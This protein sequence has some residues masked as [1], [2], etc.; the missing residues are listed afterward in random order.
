MLLGKVDTAAKVTEEITLKF[1]FRI[2]SKSL[3]KVSVLVVLD[4]SK[5]ANPLYSLR[6]KDLLKSKDP[7]V[8]VAVAKLPILN[9]KEFDLW[10]MRI[11]QYFLMT[12]YSLWEV[13]LN[14]D[15][16]S[17]TRIVDGVVQNIAPT[18]A[19]QRLAK[20]NKLKARRI[21]LMA[22]PD[23][24]QLKFNIYKDAKTLIEAIEKRLQKLLSQL[25]ILGDSISQEDINLKFL[26]SLSSEWKTHTLIWRNK[27]DLEE[28]SLDDLFN[29]LKIYEAEVEGSST[30]SQNTQ[31][32]A[33]VSS[34][35]TDS[36][37]ESVNVVL[38]VCAAS[39][40]A[41]VSTLLNVDSLSDAVIYSF[42]ASQSNSPQLDNEDLKQIDADDL[43]EMDL[44]WQMA[45]LTMR[46]RRFLQRAR[47]NLGANGTT[48]IGFDMSKVK[49]Y[50]CHRICH[51]A[52]ECRS[53]RDNKNKEAPIRTVLVEADEEPTN[54]AL[55]AYAS[56]GSSSS[57]G[58]ANEIFDSEDETDIESVPEQ[59]EPS[60]VLT[61]EHLKTPRKSVKEVEHPKQDEN[62]GTDNQQSRGHKNSWN[63]K[64]CFVCK[65]LHH[66]IKDYY[67]E[68]Q[69]VQKFVWD[70]AMRVNHQN[71]ARMTHPHSERN[72][73]PTTVL[74]RSRLVS[75]NAARPVPTVVPQSTVKS[76]SPV[77]HGNPQQAPKDKDTE[78][79]VLSSD[80][81]LLDENHVLL[82][83][84]RENNMYN[85]DHK[86]IVPT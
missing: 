57:S 35:N 29:N 56:L 68:K 33:F 86:N 69:M 83:V 18:T 16:P 79:V 62:L 2:D 22:L 11:E 70:N 39:S 74:T 67:Y 27:V 10:K 47:R 21:L 73:V 32:I 75:L 80:Y 49:C 1:R 50:N 82:R 20:K 60:S 41:T 25:E 85:V 43:E 17:P 44:K 24:H 15:S 14:G 77:K 19:Q 6:D 76:P 64:V 48:A 5:V 8:V 31:N 28:L 30:S 78:C 37:N 59:K 61:F 55:M 71:S 38:G 84:P 46:A 51:F 53:P 40:K 7:Q 12:Y 58:S 66:L 34:N 52:R 63:R 36:S 45:M 72:V 54:Y 9:P 81:K 23:K 3:N 13:I 42:F 26:R 4:L 65:S